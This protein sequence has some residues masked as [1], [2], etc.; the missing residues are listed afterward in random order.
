MSLDWNILTL[1]PHTIILLSNSWEN[2]VR[3]TSKHL[4]CTQ[5]PPNS[6]MRPCYL[7]VST[8]LNEELP[9]TGLLRGQS[10]HRFPICTAV[11]QLCYLFSFTDSHSSETFVQTLSSFRLTVGMVMLDRLV[12][13]L[14]LLVDQS[15]GKH[16][17]S[18]ILISW[19]DI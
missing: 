12:F 5:S 7:L 1:F 9:P 14:I 8:T 17:Q 15:L 2:I 4:W 18:T 11:L 6:I 16:G 13:F 19:T 3:N 10:F